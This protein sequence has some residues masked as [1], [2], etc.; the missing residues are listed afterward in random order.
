MKSIVIV[1]TIGGVVQNAILKTNDDGNSQN[2]T[3]MQVQKPDGLSAGVFPFRYGDVCNIKDVLD[4]LAYL[5]ATGDLTITAIYK[6]DAYGKT[7]ITSS[8]PVVKK[9]TVSV[10][11]EGAKLTING[12]VQKGL[13]W[14]GILAKG[15]GVTY[16]A[17]LEGYVTQEGTLTVTTSDITKSITLVT[18]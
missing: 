7:E 12:E 3:I 4:K 18:V 10:T 16:K 1:L 9:V 13:S 11:N 14:V 17:E 8:L 6:E 2:F 15:E 5:K